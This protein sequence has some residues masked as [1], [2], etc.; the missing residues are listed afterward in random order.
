MVDFKEILKDFKVPK[1]IIKKVFPPKKCVSIKDDNSIEITGI[2]VIQPFSLPKEIN[3]GD[4]DIKSIDPSNYLDLLLDGEKVNISK[5]EIDFGEVLDNIKLNLKG[6][7]YSVEE[8]L[9]G[10]AGGKTVAMGDSFSINLKM[11]EKFMAK[12]I[13]GKH[14]LKVESENFPN[15]EIEFQI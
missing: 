2:N 10:K 11:P 6:E 14:D 7:S 5:D 4:I 12:L 1:S 15:I 13:P 9:Q 8:I 3:I